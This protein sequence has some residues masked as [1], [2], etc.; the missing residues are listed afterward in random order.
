[1]AIAQSTNM[2]DL[3]ADVAQHIKDE[4]KTN[5]KLPS[6]RKV[7]TEPLVNPAV[8]PFITVTP[9][10]EVLQGYRGDKMH[11]MRTIRIELVAKKNTSKASMRQS[12]GMTEQV[13]DIFKVNSDD[14]LVPD[15]ETKSVNTLMDLE[16]VSVESSNKATPF[17]NGF[18]HVASLEFECHSFDPIFTEDTLETTYRNDSVIETDTK[19]LVDHAAGM[20]KTARLASNILSDVRSLKSFT[21]PPQPVYP[22]VFVSLEQE[23]RSHQFAGQDSVDRA[24]GINVIT[25]VKSRQKSLDRNVDLANRCRQIIMSYPD[26]NGACYKVDYVGTNYGQITGG[27]D[28]LFGTQVVFNTSSYESLPTS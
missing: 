6:V 17:R 3:V 27:G 7:S 14:Y 26:F 11:M 16:I 28:L 21:L 8:F 9:V 22:V 13:K 23:A 5:G 25:K 15:R 10:N 20:I 1:M 19:T 12:M 18:I 2:A 24:I 4:V